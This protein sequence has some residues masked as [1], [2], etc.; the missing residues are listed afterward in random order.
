MAS[1]DTGTAAGADDRGWRVSESSRWDAIR[2]QSLTPRPF[3]PFSP[4]TVFP[5]WQ[6][7]IRSERSQCDG[8]DE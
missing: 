4:S 1:N 2:T 3:H 6:Q 5:P 8:V 7:R